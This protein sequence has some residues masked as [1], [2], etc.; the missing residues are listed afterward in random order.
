MASPPGLGFHTC[1]LGVVAILALPT[2]Q[3]WVSDTWDLIVLCEP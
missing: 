3:A 2:W 1:K